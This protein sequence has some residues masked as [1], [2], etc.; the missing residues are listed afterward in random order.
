MRHI[1]ALRRTAPAPG[2]SRRP[3]SRPKI[4]VVLGLAALSGMALTGAQTAASAATV[5]TK[6]T[7]SVAVLTQPVMAT[8]TQDGKPVTKV[9]CSTTP[10]S[11]YVSSWVVLVSRTCA[12]CLDCAGYCLPDASVTPVITYG[13][14]YVPSEASVAYVFPEWGFFTSFC[15]LTEN[16]VRYVDDIAPGTLAALK[17]SGYDE[18]RVAY[19]QPAQREQYEAALRQAG[20]HTFTQRTFATLDGRPVFYLLEGR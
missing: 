2:E 14:Q 11:R 4:R 8:V 6:K 10:C 15:L 13:L 12:H 1:S 9:P 16:K 17:Q 3:R 20:I 19:W 18:F 5:A 7:V